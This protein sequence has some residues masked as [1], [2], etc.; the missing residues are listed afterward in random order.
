MA[1]Y[2]ASPCGLVSDEEGETPVFESTAAELGNVTRF[3]M[4]ELSIISPGLDTKAS[5]SAPVITMTGYD[6]L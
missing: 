1:L 5:L 3:R 6:S 2:L 4:P